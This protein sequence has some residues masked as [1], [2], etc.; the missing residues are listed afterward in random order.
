MVAGL[1]SNVAQSQKTKSGLTAVETLDWF[2][3]MSLIRRF[4]E[5][6]EE[7]WLMTKQKCVHNVTLLALR[8]FRMP[9]PSS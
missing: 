3:K 7:A 6:A 1:D 4:E 2:K 9:T 5:R 8:E